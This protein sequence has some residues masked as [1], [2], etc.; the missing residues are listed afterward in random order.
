MASLR[1]L[2]LRNKYND[3]FK[4]AFHACRNEID[5]LVLLLKK[6]ESSDKELSLLIETALISAERINLLNDKMPA[7]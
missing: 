5:S 7:G 2:H 4:A 1:K 6:Y 3:L